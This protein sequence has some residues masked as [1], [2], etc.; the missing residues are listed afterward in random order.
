MILGDPVSTGA[1]IFTNSP[2]QEAY[3]RQKRGHVYKDLGPALSHKD[4]HARAR[5]QVLKFQV[6]PKTASKVGAKFSIT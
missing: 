1:C 3:T 2:E 5:F 4:L 6:Y